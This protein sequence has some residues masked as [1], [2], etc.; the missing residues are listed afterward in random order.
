MDRERADII[1]ATRRGAPREVTSQPSGADR[2]TVGR[3]FRTGAGARSTLASHD[4]GSL[5]D[6]GAK[7]RARG[8]T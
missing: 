2:R 8:G 3:A 7:H 6:L 5:R 4:S 1:R